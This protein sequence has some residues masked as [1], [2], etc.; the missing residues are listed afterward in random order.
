MPFTRRLQASSSDALPPGQCTPATKISG[1][2]AWQD[3][4]ASGDQS[5]RRIASLT[6]AGLPLPAMAFIT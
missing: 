1:R 4:A 3:R 2:D 6:S 5:L